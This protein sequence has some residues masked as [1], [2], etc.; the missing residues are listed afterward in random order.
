MMDNVVTTVGPPGAVGIAR[1]R[2]LGQG[3]APL[4]ELP[5]R[6]IGRRE[7]TPGGEQEPP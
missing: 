5:F 3:H 4:E 6:R 2:A 7:T 1:E